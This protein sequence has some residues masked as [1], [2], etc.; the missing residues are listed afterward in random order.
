MDL[1]GAS[2]VGIAAKILD[3]P[4]G[5]IEGLHEGLKAMLEETEGL[6]LRVAP[7]GPPVLDAQTVAFIIVVF[8]RLNPGVRVSGIKWGT[9]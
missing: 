6:T 8:K 9:A 1:K 5:K 3:G 2:A 4:D 7:S